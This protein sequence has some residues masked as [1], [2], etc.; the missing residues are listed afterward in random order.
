MNEAESFAHVQMKKIVPALRNIEGA[1]A[2]A[3]NSLINTSDVN[4]SLENEDQPSI[5]TQ[6]HRFDIG[7]YPIL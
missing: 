7:F 6:V 1:L 3:K 5:A 4:Q 2:C